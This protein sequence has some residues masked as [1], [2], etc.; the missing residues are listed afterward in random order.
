MRLSSGLLLASAC[1][2]LGQFNQFT[3][4]TNT[5]TSAIETSTPP[6]EFETSSVPP[7][8]SIE[9]TSTSVESTASASAS[10]FAPIVLNLKDAILGPGASFY[11]PPD[12]DTI[13]MSPVATDS[14]LKRRAGPIPFP[15]TPP[16]DLP[17]NAVST[18]KT[19]IA[20]A[21]GATVK[22]NI[23]VRNV[24][25]GGA[26]V[27]SA[28]SR[29]RAESS[30][31]ALQ[32]FSNGEVVQIQPIPE[33][34]SGSL[35]IPTNPFI[36]KLENE[37][38]L[39]Q[40][41]GDVIVPVIIA[42]VTL[43]DAQGAT[44][45]PIPTP[46]I[47][48]PTGSKTGSPTETNTAEF[49]TNSE[50]ETIFPTTNSQNFTT[51]SK[52][53][54]DFPTGTGIA[55]N[56]EGATTNSE[57]QTIFPTGTGVNTNSEGATTNSKGET[58]FPT[59]T[60]TDTVSSASSTSTS[61]NAGFPGDVGGFSLF[62]CAGS[63]A[64]F[65]TYA[66]V[67]SSALMDL[68]V[69]AGLCEGRA[70]FGVHD[71][72]C[73]CGD[74]YDFDSTVWYN[75]DQCD[76]ECPGD[77]TQFCGGEVEHKLQVRQ[78]ISSSILLTLY[79]KAEAAI[80]L[81][82]SVMQTLTSQETII[83][84]LTTVTSGKSIATEVVTATLVNGSNCDGQWVYI[85]EP[86]A[87]GQQYIPHSCSDGKCAGI[88][89]YKPQPCPDWYNY[90]SYYTPSDCNKCAQGKISYQPWEKSWGT[91]D[92]CNDQVPICNT[93]ECP[94]QQSVVR[95]HHGISWNSTIPHGGS[96]GV[97][98]PSPNGGSSG[99]SSS[100][101]N[102]GSSGGSSGG[103]GA[104]SNK[105]SS[106]GS[107]GGTEGSGSPGSEGSSPS[108]VPVVSGAIKR[109]SDH[110]NRLR[111]EGY[112]DHYGRS[113]VSTAVTRTSTAFITDYQTATRTVTSTDT[114]SDTYTLQRVG[115]IT[116]QVTRTTTQAAV[117]T[118]T[119]VVGTAI[120]TVVPASVVYTGGSTTISTILYTTTT[121]TAAASLVVIPQA[122]VHCGVV[123]ATDDVPVDGKGGS[124]SFGECK[125]ICNGWRF[126][127]LSSERCLCY[128]SRLEDYVVVDTSSD[129][130]F[131]NLACD[132]ATPPVKHRKR[133]LQAAVS[134]PSYLPNKSPSAVR[135][136]CSCLITKPAAAVAAKITAK[137]SETVTTTKTKEVVS[138]ITNRLSTL[139]TDKKTG[140]I[141]LSMTTTITSFQT[142]A[143]TKHLGATTTQVETYI[144]TDFDHLVYLYKTQFVTATNFNTITT[145]STRTVPNTRYNT[146]V[147]TSTQPTTVT[148]DVYT[149]SQTVLST[150]T[151]F[152]GGSTIPSGTTTIYGTI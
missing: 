120:T 137:A 75:L 28:G 124:V 71:T 66:L 23:V 145:T 102:G 146:V 95:P 62:G 116:Q 100:G 74:V 138:T 68:D 80:S 149:T 42:G 8:G 86:C 126:F 45:T 97:Y 91:P 64:G 3:R 83:T 105:G 98:N 31:C 50:G 55:T 93:L 38:K 32:V 27:C 41:C 14:T 107:Q 18:L 92:N 49:T 12:G 54:T 37:L 84:T 2:A 147:V 122:Q 77:K 114:P 140:T 36:P 43:Q 106:S 25:C 115:T 141:I 110:Q 9:T 53:E 30:P 59:G 81:T 144:V 121:A 10:A 99:G 56:S 20:V 90:K 96:G 60:S 48:V 112:Q 109:V 76:I 125:E 94:S 67:E 70:Y 61:I 47:G 139:V 113:T 5:S 26:V 88:K 15:V 63:T 152:T 35:E 142:V 108:T 130:T 131:Y 19:A 46:S 13:L 151:V 65:P 33:T 16:L 57:G 148:K 44:P 87:G 21:K 7:T 69:C 143:Q 39:Q 40:A 117:T 82:E 78:A 119:T 34:F 51:N 29:K 101:S 128:P 111:N 150:R 104:S 118:V 6:A 4:F 72:A 129:T 133:A 89:V 1:S 123:G 24:T 136:A 132:S 127:G 52:G 73:Y 135:S 58:V 85:S 22:Y 17:N 11:P 134:V 103:S 79:A